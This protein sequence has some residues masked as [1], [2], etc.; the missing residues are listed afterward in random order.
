M[1]SAQPPCL[2]VSAL[3]RNRPARRRRQVAGGLYLDDHKNPTPIDVPTVPDLLADRASTQPDRE[4]IRVVGSPSALTFAEWEERSH[5]VA[6]NLLRKGIR[7]G[8][9]VGLLFDSGHWPEFAIAYCA[10]HKAAAVAVP[11]SDKA[12]VAEI[13]YAMRACAASLLVGAVHQRIPAARTVP[14]ADLEDGDHDELAAVRAA[15]ADLAQIL[16]TSGTGG[17]PKGVGATHQNVTFGYRRSPRR[18][19]FAHSE[20]FVHA[21]PIGTN[22]GQM[23]LLN[24]LVVHPSMLVQEHFDAEQFCRTVEERRIGTVFVVPAMAIEIVNSKAYERHDLTSVRLLSSS[25]SALP[26]SVARALTAIFSRA[27]VVNC[28]TSTESLPA[29]VMMLV[30]REH[31]DSVGLPLGDVDIEI[32]DGTGSPLGHREVGDVWLRCPTAPRTYYGDTE[33]TAKTFRDGWVRMGDVGW[34]DQDGLLYLV[35]RETEV[36]KSGALRISTTEVE[37]VLLEHP[38]VR[39]AAVLGLPHP[40]LGT[41]VAAVVVVDE[42]ASLRDVRAFM[43]ERLAQNKIPV[44]WAVVPQLPRNQ[45]GK[46]VK[47]KLRSLFSPAESTVRGAGT[48]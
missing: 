27:S 5:R 40:V 43:R 11:M 19:P 48:P 28:Y 42:G 33:A 44:R 1:V 3:A 41:M 37:S 22:A 18:R 30:D 45:M 34:L 17:K 32:L 16:Y 26:P 9:R 13:D 47:N 23:M 7:P 14:F 24:A 39:E 36:I 15:P 2:L 8:D 29:Q 25:G 12:S 38:G 10:V 4:A 31:P 6:G 20:Q 46:I 35:D 21:F